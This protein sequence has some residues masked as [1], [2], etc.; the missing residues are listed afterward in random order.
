MAV[1]GFNDRRFADAFGP[2]L[3]TFRI[4]QYEPGWVTAAELLLTVL[5][6]RFTCGGRGDAVLPSHLTDLVDA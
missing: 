3:T 5:G 2:P 1:A 6:T 4:R